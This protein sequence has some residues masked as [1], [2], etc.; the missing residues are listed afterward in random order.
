MPLTT[1]VDAASWAELTPAAGQNIAPTLAAGAR[2]PVYLVIADAA[3]AGAQ[4]EP[5]DG[6]EA[7][8]LSPAHVGGVFLTV[9]AGKSV[10]ARCA[11]AGAS[12]RV[13]VMTW[14]PTP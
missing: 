10:Y 9:A 4:T 11:E 12:Q 2:W 8:T 5:A 13:N 14:T 3:P 1:T 6:E 7:I